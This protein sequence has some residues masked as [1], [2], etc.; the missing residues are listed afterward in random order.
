MINKVKGL[1]SELDTELKWAW[2]IVIGMACVMS[3]GYLILFFLWPLT[4]LIITG[5]L[6]AITLISVFIAAL[7][8]LADEYGW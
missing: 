2:G 8:L 4:M 6:L 3:F 1:W 7:V 5:I